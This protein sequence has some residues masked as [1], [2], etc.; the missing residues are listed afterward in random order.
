MSLKVDMSKAYDGVEL[1]YLE[2]TM[3]VLSFPQRLVSLIMHCVKKASFL[4]IVNGEES[5][6]PIFLSRGL[7]QR[8]PLSPYLFLLCTDGLISLL[9]KVALKQ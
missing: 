5:E 2:L 3:K 7:R 4:V 8:D 6:G 1:D 9:K